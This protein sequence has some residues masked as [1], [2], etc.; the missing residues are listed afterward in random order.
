MGILGEK[1]EGFAGT[2]IK[3]AWTKT[4]GGGNRGGWWEGLGSWGGVG[5]KGRKLYLINNSKNV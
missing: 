4:S 2:I 3:D 5:G 1:G